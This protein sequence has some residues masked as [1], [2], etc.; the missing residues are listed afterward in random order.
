M[1]AGGGG[2]GGAIKC[3]RGGGGCR[4]GCM[5]KGGGG[6]GYT[7]LKWRRGYQR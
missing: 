2:N 5:T 1:G 4:T 7:A 6:A 3:M